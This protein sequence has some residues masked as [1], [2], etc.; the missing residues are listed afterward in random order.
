M[1]EF[2]CVADVDK[3]VYNTDRG[4]EGEGTRMLFFLFCC[5]CEKHKK[6]RRRTLSRVPVSGPW[7]EWK[8][9]LQE[10]VTWVDI[11]REFQ[12]EPWQ[13]KE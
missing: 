11:L 12:T 2:C 5:V 4:V 1:E 8:M 10:A 3:V 9:T 13:Y 7:R 6:A